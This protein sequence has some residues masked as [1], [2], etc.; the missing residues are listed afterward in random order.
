MAEASGTIGDT[1]DEKKPAWGNHSGR[2]LVNFWDGTIME[3][4][5]GSNYADREYNVDN[6]VK[7]VCSK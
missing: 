3:A 6:F 1:I 4:D 7:A 5:W 2:W